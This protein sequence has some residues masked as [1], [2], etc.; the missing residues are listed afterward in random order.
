MVKF[1]FFLILVA[2]IIAGLTL[3]PTLSP[4]N[5]AVLDVMERVLCAPDE[6]LTQQSVPA[7]SSGLSL[8]MR[9]SCKPI[10]GNPYPV[11][12]KLIG[13]GF[14][15]ALVFAV[16]GILFLLI[17]IIRNA[18]GSNNTPAPVPAAAYTSPYYNPQAPAPQQVPAAPPMTY[19]SY[20]ASLGRTVSTTVT[21]GP[22]SNKFDFDAGATMMS[23][24]KQSAT[25]PP[26][27]SSDFSFDTAAT[28]TSVPKTSTP[29]TPTPVVTSESSSSS[30]ALKGRLQQLRDALDAGLIT[31]EE[32]D[33]SKS[34]LLRDF[35]DV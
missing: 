32:F 25:P 22:P 7:A 26:A 1:S 12:D 35:T 11:T 24:P 29:A 6:N 14:T 28:M 4:N 23:I 3:S 27:P 21:D 5:A 16:F 17:G 15:A 19:T 2:V 34:D 18:T 30:S 9:L 13:M 31:Q 10:G 20:N 8:D 33:R